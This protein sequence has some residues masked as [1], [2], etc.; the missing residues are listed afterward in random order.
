MRKF[1][2][3]KVCEKAKPKDDPYQIFDTA[4]TGFVL[5]VQPTGAKFFKLVPRKDGYQSNKPLTIGKMPVWTEGMARGKAERILRGED[6]V[7]LAEADLMTLDAFIEKHYTPFVRVNHSAPDDTIARLNRFGLGDK[8]LADIKLA[9]LETWRIQRQDDGVSAS[10]INRDTATLRSALQKAVDWELIDT[11][12]LARLKPLKTD[13]RKIVRYLNTNEEKR[14][15]AA[16]VGRDERKRRERDSANAWRLE[17]GY[18]LLPTIGTYADNLTPLV[19]LAINTG[20][21]RGELWNLTWGDINLRSKMLTVHGKGAKSGQTR[22]IPLNASALKALKKHRGGVTPLPRNPVF[23]RSEF[24]KAFSGVLKDAK[25]KQFRF[26]DTR[27][28]FA[29]K[30]VMAGVPL[31]TVR[32]LMG[33]SSLDMTLIYAHLAPDNLRAAVDLI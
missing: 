17:R 11:H 15:M 7:E 9:D 29:S 8:Y 28:T 10:T 31:N 20:L 23:G 33:H 16:L 2:T 3:Q 18:D 32:E 5:R 22:H 27:H 12:P 19:I 24:R 21:R 4:I 25:I 1:L 26:H 6:D 13:R 14:L 30:L